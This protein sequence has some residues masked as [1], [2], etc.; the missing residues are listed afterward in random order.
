MKVSKSVSIYLLFAVFSLPLSACT[1]FVLR[2]E[3]SVMVAKNLDW[4]VGEGIIV[5][6]RRA[7]E[8]TSLLPGPGSPL[9][10]RSR[11]GSVTFNLLGRGFPLGGMNEKGLVIEEANYSP[12][13]YPRGTGNQVNE[14]QWIQYHLDTCDTTAAVLERLKQVTIV[15]ILARVHYMICDASGRAAVVEFIDGRARVYTGR[16]LVVPVMTN[17]SYRNSLKSLAI[18]QGFGGQRTV[19][20]GPESPERFVRAAI[21]LSRF[22]NNPASRPADPGFR[23]LDA[24]VQQD[25]QWGVVYDLIPRTIRFRTLGNPVVRALRLKD[26]DFQRTDAVADINASGAVLC[27]E[28]WTVKKNTRLLNRVFARMV[29][30]GV[31]DEPEATVLRDRLIAYSRAVRGGS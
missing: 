2:Q 28:P 16:D 1:V 3:N 21:L 25:T 6:N 12:S 22:Q 7:V 20:N 24:V 11:F 10:W 15:P 17:T 26:F 30:L 29:R 5:V 8:K 19:G 9:A 13:R 14:S 18:H 23:I 4:P 27:F 31:A